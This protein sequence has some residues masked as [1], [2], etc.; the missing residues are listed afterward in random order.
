MVYLNFKL[1]T[2]QLKKIIFRLKFKITFYYYFKLNIFLYN[3]QDI[4]Y[5]TMT[6]LDNHNVTLNEGSNYS[7]SV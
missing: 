1:R 7:N 5:E 4:S 6:L 2:T 3:N